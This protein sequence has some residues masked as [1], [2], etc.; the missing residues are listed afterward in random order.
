M[1]FEKTS[2]N[3]K[4]SNLHFL[5]LNFNQF[6]HSV[7]FSYELQ[8]EMLKKIKLSLIFIFLKEKKKVNLKFYKEVKSIKSFYYF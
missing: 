2:K 4:T 1:R 3:L 8:T 5:T 6:I 7:S